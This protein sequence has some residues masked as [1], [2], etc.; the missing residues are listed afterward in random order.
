MFSLHLSV[1]LV[2]SEDKNSEIRDTVHDVENIRRQ[3]MLTKA[4]FKLG[5]HLMDQLNRPVSD[6]QRK[7]FVIGNIEPDFNPFSYLRGFTRE[8]SLKG[9][10]FEVTYKLIDRK[11]KYLN[12]KKRWNTWDYFSFGVLMHYLAD[13]F[14]YPHNDSF[15]GTSKEHCAYEVAHYPVLFNYLHKQ[16]DAV[17]I[18]I[19]KHG[20]SQWIKESHESYEKLAVS[21]ERDCRY[22]YSMCVN[23]VNATVPGRVTEKLRIPVVYPAQTATMKG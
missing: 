19:D 23:A 20:V 1:K 13:G 3:V 10:N 16:A 21:F 4:H 18:A 15:K 17:K 6:L 8:K 22:I 12:R 9:H 2:T 5:K 11:L 7:A 14:T